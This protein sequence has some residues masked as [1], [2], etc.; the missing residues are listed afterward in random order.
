MDEG[1]FVLDKILKE[2]TSERTTVGVLLYG[3]YATGRITKSSVLYLLVLNEGQWW[4]KRAFEIDGIPVDIQFQSVDYCQHKIKEEKFFTMIKTF[5]DG[6]ILY[7]KGETLTN[8]K[9]LAKEVY[10]DGPDKLSQEEVDK[11]RLTTFRQYTEIKE[12]FS[13]YP[14]TAVMLMTNAFQPILNNFFR[15][16]RL[17]LGDRKY[18]LAELRKRDPNFHR[19]CIKFLKSTSPKEEFIIL[20]QIYKYVLTPV[21]GF[22]KAAR[23]KVKSGYKKRFKILMHPF[24]LLKSMYE[25][26]TTGEVSR[27]SKM[28]NIVRFMH[29]LKPY[30]FYFFEV[31]LFGLFSTLMILP[32]PYLAKI[33]IDNVLPNSNFALLN[34]ILLAVLALTLFKGLISF[35]QGYYTIYI[36]QLMQYDI[37]FKFYEHLLKLPYRFYDEEETGQ[38]IFRFQDATSALQII[39]DLILKFLSYTL[40]ALIIPIVIFIIDW[41]LALFSA[42]IL[43][44]NAYSYHK[45]SQFVY[46]YTKQ[47]TAQRAEYTA[48][49]YESISGMKLIQALTL[50]NSILRKMK[51]LYLNIRKNLV[52]LRTIV[53][54]VEAVNAAAG[55]IGTFIVMWFA[56]HRILTGELTFGS[57]IAFGVL[58]GFLFGPIR[59]M[60]SIGPDIQRGMVRAERFFRMYDV[61]PAIEET[62]DTIEPTRIRGNI[63]FKDVFFEYEFER[64]ILS[65][66]NLEIEAGTTVALVGKSGVGK[67]TFVNLI[68]RFYDHTS[69][70]ISIDGIDIRKINVK[71]LRDRIGI[72]PQDDFLFEGTIKEN[73]KLGRRG[74]TDEEIIAA[75][76]RANIH[77]FIMSLPDRY[78]TEISERGTQLSAGEKKRISIARA[79]IRN[80]NILILDEATSSLD[81]ESEELIYEALKKARKE[82][83]TFIIAHRLS[84]IKDADIIL[85]FEGGRI[86]AKGKHDE[87]L[88]TSNIY[89][90]LFEKM[91]TV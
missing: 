19:Y 5:I 27:K 84:T 60:I 88:R 36:S 82:R 67:T 16:R 74:A 64:S 38:I 49:A 14:D 21:G 43:P 6:K 81:L 23:T 20:S 48:K 28:A 25:Q 35:A 2:V 8:L 87:L 75:A 34:F 31:T 85:V 9:Q 58:V 3:A 26:I 78:E 45:L 76:E 29:F 39:S 56:W 73:I 1:K 42:I 91:T 46:K 51:R 47:V 7:E 68:P 41:K 50:E 30:K 17:W 33:L 10:L 62:S 57:L 18:M 77:D 24:K 12:T 70:E 69:G 55:A 61:P 59:G 11:I 53:M 52:R 37:R 72:V 65:D 71:F 40:S 4:Q 54:G 32:Y 66:I 79:L 80:P 83:T 13:K 44:F 63:K 86:V 22:L 90:K 15:L 89:R